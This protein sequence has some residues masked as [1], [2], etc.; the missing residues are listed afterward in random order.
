MPGSSRNQRRQNSKPRAVSRLHGYNVSPEI[1]KRSRAREN[2]GPRPS[3]KIER[4]SS[5]PHSVA[6]VVRLPDERHTKS[7]TQ[8][9]SRSPHQERQANRSESNIGSRVGNR[10]SGRCGDQ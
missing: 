3:H 9:R 10:T 4:A 1:P 5:R 6:S 8:S 2:D 7:R